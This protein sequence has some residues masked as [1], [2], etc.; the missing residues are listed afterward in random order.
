MN[1]QVQEQII[2]GTFEPPE[3]LHPLAKIYLKYLQ[4]DKQIDIELPFEIDFQKFCK[5]K[6][7]T[8]CS[9]S[10]RTY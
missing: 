2:D 7:K 6:E 3:S 10:G 5:A 4:R 1:T 9:P 8:S